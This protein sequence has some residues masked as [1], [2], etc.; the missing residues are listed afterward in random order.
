MN[1]IEQIIKDSDGAWK[2]EAEYFQWLRGQL[3]EIWKWHPVRTGYLKSKKYKWPGSVR[4]DTRWL[5]DCEI[6][7]TPCYVYRRVDGKLLPTEIQVDHKHPS[8]SFKSKEDV[9]QFIY[10]LLF[11]TW[12]DLRCLCLPCH[13]IV[14]ISQRLGISFEEAEIEKQVI[15][16]AKKPAAEQVSELAAVGL[17]GSNA[18]QRKECY[19]K[20]LKEL[21]GTE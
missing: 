10:R 13:G 15:D 6:C 4:G 18:K 11:I 3:R 9:L 1:T 8:G 17:F 12:A 20:H 2:T 7:H 14:T 19:R 16:F 21:N 5:V